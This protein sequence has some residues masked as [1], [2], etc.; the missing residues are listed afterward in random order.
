MNDPSQN[1]TATNRAKVFSRLV[2]D[3][4]ISHGAF[5]VYHLLNDYA[6]KK[7]ICWPAM[8]TIATEIHCKLNSVVIWIAELEAAGYITI[9]TKGKNHFNVYRLT[10]YGVTHMDNA[11]NLSR[12][13]SGTVALPIGA[14]RVTQKGNGIDPKNVPQ[15]VKTVSV[16][17][18]STL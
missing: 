17:I 15:E 16:K 9:T 2:R 12:Y 8:R 6:G 13:P 18:Q 11:N 14:R 3:K 5:R 1:T 10:N 4:T 7:C